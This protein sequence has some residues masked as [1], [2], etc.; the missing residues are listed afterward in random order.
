MNNKLKNL[1]IILGLV[2][3]AFAGYYLYSQQSTVP[4]GLGETDLQ[5]ENM[6]MQTQEFIQRRQQLG[7]TNLDINLFENDGFTTLHTY[8]DPIEEVEVGRSD[9]FAQIQSF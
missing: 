8:S 7:Q 5:Y 2:T 1:L 9:P 3:V 6:L 4:G